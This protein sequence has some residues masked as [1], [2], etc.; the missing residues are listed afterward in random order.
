MGLERLATTPISWGFVG[1]NRWGVDLGAERILTEMGALGFR[2]TEAGVPGFLP[3]DVGAARDLLARFGMTPIAGPV[4]FLAHVPSEVEASLDRVRAAADRLAALGATVLMTV[5]KRGD[6][7][8]GDRLDDATWKRVLDVLA[9]VEEIAADRGLH[10]AV[11]PHVGSLVETVEDMD[12]VMGDPRIGWCLDTAHIASGGQDPV[13]FVRDAG[14][15]V[16]HFHLKDADLDLGRRMVRHEIPFD[17]AIKARVFRPLGQGDVDIAAI[18]DAMAHRTDIWWVL[19]Q[20][21]ACPSVPADGEGPVLEAKAS[22]DWFT[23]YLSA[24][25][26]IS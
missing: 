20:D 11:H 2:A 15:R 14:D 18:A 4:S 17:D 7:A 3:A 22:R 10:Q 9:R 25:G 24:K 5:P 12:R 21:L 19:E 6:L 1:G 23:A 8:G 16:H 26:A 13:Q